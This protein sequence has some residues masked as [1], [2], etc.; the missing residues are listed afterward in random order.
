MS[1]VFARDDVN[2]AIALAAS[3]L[4]Y[5]QLRPEQKKAVREFLNGSD[6]FVSLPTGS[7]KSLCYAVLPAVFDILRHSDSSAAMVIVVSPLISLM[8]DQVAAFQKKGV[9]AVHVTPSD[10]ETLLAVMAG[11]FQLIYISPETLLTDH[12]W[13]DVLR[14]PLF[15]KNL[16]GLVIDEAHCVKKW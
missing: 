11:D 7:G 3:R 14:S 1:S 12:E 16:V 8:K 5:V 10:S 13:R 2:K 9:K 4:G 15:Q 6:V